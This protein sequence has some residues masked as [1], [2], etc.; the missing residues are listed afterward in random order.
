MKFNLNAVLLIIAAS[1]S[2][3][4]FPMCAEKPAGRKAEIAPAPSPTVEEMVTDAQILA[5]NANYD[6]AVEL[7]EKVLE[8][9]SNNIEALKLLAR[10]YA[11][12]GE[13]ENS[14]LMWAKLFSL[15]PGDPDAAYEVGVSLARKKQWSLVRSKMLEFSRVGK[16][17]GRH[18]LLIGEA[19]IE[20]GYRKEA[21]KYLLM[22]GNVER[23]KFLLGKL[24]YSEGKLDTAEKT[25]R[26]VLSINPEHFGS[27]LHLGWLYYKKGYRSKALRHYQAAVKLDPSSTIARLS[28]ARLLEEL[29]KED[30]AIEQ[31]KGALKPKS[32]AIDEKK[33]AY[34]TLCNLLI[35][36]GRTEEAIYYA[37]KGLREFPGSG[38]LYYMWGIALL[39]QGDRS[40]A[41]AKLRLA[42]KDPRWSDIASRQIR[43]LMR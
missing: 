1:A 16:P 7:L 15:N 35:K 10:V 34:I 25:F 8:E 19:D 33:R 12:M 22:A 21:K 37:N 31:Y 39:K 42:A 11:A 3:I 24:Y 29:G 38:G 32:R 36:R 41:M 18:F 28:L 14:S 5:G 27:H 13:K 9:D 2:I 4:L 30:E 40:S 20:L 17:D 26:E 6:R 43:K 23:A